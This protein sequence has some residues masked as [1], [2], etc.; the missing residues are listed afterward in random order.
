VRELLVLLKKRRS[1]MGRKRREIFENF[2]DFWLQAKIMWTIHEN[3][4]KISTT[5]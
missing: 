4:L 5:E 1:A 3:C 2:Y